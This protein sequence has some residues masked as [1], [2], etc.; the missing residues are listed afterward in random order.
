MLLQYFM[1]GGQGRLSIYEL[2]TTTSAVL[3][4]V[5][6]ELSIARKNTKSETQVVGL[7]PTR[8][9]IR[10]RNLVPCFLYASDPAKRKASH[11][12]ATL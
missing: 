8:P 5:T 7:V 9:S 2:A 1:D 12:R 10:S 4:L 11:M 3:P 6:D